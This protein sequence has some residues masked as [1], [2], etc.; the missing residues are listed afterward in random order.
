MNKNYVVNIT[1]YK[2]VPLDD[3]VKL[4]S[5]YQQKCDGLLLK[6]T[7]LISN[8]GINF[9]LAG[10]QKA[11]DSIIAFLEK[12]KRFYEILKEEV[13]INITDIFAISGITDN[14]RVNQRN[15]CFCFFL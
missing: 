3:V 2:F 12:D 8:N 1:G 14:I 9:S 15:F 13:C 5:L 10:T 11:T 4:V 6:G 7:M